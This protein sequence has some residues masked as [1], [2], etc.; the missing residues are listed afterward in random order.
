MGK[1]DSTGQRH[2]T[3]ELRELVRSVRDGT[4]HYDGRPKK[5]LDWSTYDELQVREVS[6][7]LEL[8]RKFVDVASGRVQLQERGR[9]RPPV[10]P[11]S[12]VAKALLLQ[13]YFGVSNRVAAGLVDLF[14]EKLG[15]SKSF[16]YKTIERGYDPSPVTLILQQV[17]SLTNELG[18]AKED[19]FSFDGSGDPASSKVNYESVRSE[20][21]RASDGPVDW[22]GSRHDFQY[23]LSSV[24]VHTRLIGGFKS[25]AAGRLVGELSMLPGVLSQTYRNC[26]GMKVALGDALYSTRSACALVA[27]YGVKPYFFPKQNSTFRSHGVPAWKEMMYGLVE[28]P[29]G[30]LRVY[31]MRSIS[32]SVNSVDKRRFPWKLKK[33]LPWRKETESF[34]RRDVYNVRQYSYLSCLQPDMVVK[35]TG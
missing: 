19:T 11:P 32:E 1:E 16:S 23:G 26:P 22:Q 5:S 17:F 7:M 12:D 6:S 29:Q 9:G 20:Q 28:D 24:G 4:F 13:S 25:S 3:E 30:W 10:Y 31:H 21:R 14:K 8:I 27:Q 33:R 2:T 35:L 34:L 18:N 15:I